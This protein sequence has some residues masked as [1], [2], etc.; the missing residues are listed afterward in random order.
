MEAADYLVERGV[1]TYGELVQAYVHAKRLAAV[2]TD[3]GGEL[4]ESPKQ[5]VDD[6]LAYEP[7]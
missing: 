3:E 7:S 2:N 5:V 1:Y 6:D 4:M